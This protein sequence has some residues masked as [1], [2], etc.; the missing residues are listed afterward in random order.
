MKKYLCKV[1]GVEVEVEEGE[2]CPVCGAD[3]SEL[4]P[5]EEEK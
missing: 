5:V 4:E 1:C 3:F 2:A